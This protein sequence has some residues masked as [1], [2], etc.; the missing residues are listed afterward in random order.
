MSK[1]LNEG[2]V[3][4]SKFGSIPEWDFTPQATFQQMLQQMMPQNRE[5]PKS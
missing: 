5:T 1:F 4:T 3:D 2:I